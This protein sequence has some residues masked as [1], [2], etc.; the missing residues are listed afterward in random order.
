[1]NTKIKALLALGGTV[2]FFSTGVIVAR[3]V[4][5]EVSP[6]LLL[7][8]RML[9][10]AVVFLPFIFKSIVWK[11]PKFKNLVLVSLLSTINVAFFLWGIQYT[12]ASASQFVYATQPILTILISNYLLKERYPTRSFFGVG[13]GLIGIAFIIY[14]SAVEKGETITGSL[15]GN[16]AMVIAMSGW[17]WYILLSKKMSKFFTPMEIS[18]ISIFVSL[19]VSIVLLLLQT[20]IAS[21]P[22]ILS[23]KAIF[24][25][26]YMGFFSTFLTYILT[27]YAIKYLT[28]LTVNL[29]SYIQPI[30]VTILAIILLGERLTTSFSIGSLLVF[31]GIFLSTTLELY[32]RRK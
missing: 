28:S 29:T 26:I 27:Q 7:F 14:Q 1:M 24:A 5:I 15:V 25:G 17:L 12:S 9:V 21:I 32:K 20:T 18:G 6:M 10:A 22:I 2:V 13:V 31:A 19:L 16:I 30:V 11:K 8:L 4:V 23:W 3:A